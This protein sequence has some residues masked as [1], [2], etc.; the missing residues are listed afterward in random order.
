MLSKDFLL[1]V[2]VAICI[3]I[4]LSWWIMWAWLDG[5]AY[6]IALSVDI[7]LLTAVSV[8]LVTL[9]TVSFQAVDAAIANPVK[10]LETE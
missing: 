8:V 7:F 4:P 9:L 2:L 3:A 6:H 5:F 1:C 10:S